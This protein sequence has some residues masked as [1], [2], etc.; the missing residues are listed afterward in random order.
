MSESLSAPVLD[1]G[2][3]DAAGS[4]ATAA[5]VRRASPLDATALQAFVDGAK[6][7]IESD[8]AAYLQTV[9]AAIQACRDQ[10]QP[11]KAMRLV[12]YRA[13]ACDILGRFE[14]AFATMIQVHQ[15]AVSLDDVLMQAFAIG[16]IGGFLVSRGDAA[17]AI[18]HLEK[19]L[20]MHRAA[21]DARGVAATLNNLGFAYLTMRGLEARAIELFAEARQTWLQQGVQLES[22]LALANVACAELSL[23]ERLGPHDAAAAQAA[24]GRAWVAAEQ[25]GREVEGLSVPRVALDARIA[26]A[27]AATLLGRHAEAQAHFDAAGRELD[28]YPSVVLQTDLLTG[29]GRLSCA[30][31]APGRA[32]RQFEQAAQLARDNSLPV[33][34]LRALRGLA[35]ALEQ[36]GDLAGALRTLRAHHELS[37]Q[38]HDDDAQRQARNLTS[39]LALERAEHAAQVERLRSAWLEEQNALLA[40]HALQDGLTGLPNRRAFDERLREFLARGRDARVLALA[41]LDHF[42]AI[43]D[44]HSHMVGDE[45]LRRMG[46]LLRRGV[47]DVDFAARIGGEEFALLLAGVDAGNAL[48]LCERLR[49]LV[50][51]HDWTTLAP[52]L[53]VTLS[54]GLAEVRP[55]DDGAAVLVHADRALYAAKA[56]GRNRVLVEPGEARSAGA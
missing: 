50:A 37:E 49:E 2:A 46:E 26:L 10:G 42:K 28:A 18:E 27:G 31:G 39:R 8:P 43:N 11:D 54:I 35:S 21:D 53:R 22:A 6:A 25:A 51:G 7:L 38:L 12:Y 19:A 1:P 17:G 4:A 48:A 29:L 30:V 33:K 13:C 36:G 56:A 34:H 44:R 24:A 9:D 5:D 16:G 32:V 41:D 55:G 45:V 20:P 3:A 40:A 47:R 52:G 14:E 23:A 15:L